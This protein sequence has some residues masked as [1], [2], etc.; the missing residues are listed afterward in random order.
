MAFPIA[1]PIIFVVYF[2]SFRLNCLKINSIKCCMH[3][4]KKKKIAHSVDIIEIKNIYYCVYE[5]FKHVILSYLYLTSNLSR[6]LLSLILTIHN[7][8]LMIHLLHTIAT[9]NTKK[10]EMDNLIT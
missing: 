3:R 2:L 1:I 9:C 6:I 5:A 7:F 10:N 4:L 8:I